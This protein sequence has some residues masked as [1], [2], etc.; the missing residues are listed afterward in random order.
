[1]CQKSLLFLD[2]LR[3]R[4]AFAGLFPIC[5]CLYYEIFL[6]L[7]DLYCFWYNDYDT[8]K[9]H[10]IFEWLFKL[11]KADK[12]A[13][14]LKIKEEI[15]ML[16]VE[17]PKCSTCQRAKKWLNERGISY[18]DRDIKVQNPSADELKEWH[19]KSGLPLKKFFNTSG[20]LYKEMGLKDKLP[21]MSE[22]EQFQVLASDGMLVKRPI[23]VGDEVVLVG[24][25]E[26]EWEI[27]LTGD[28][29]V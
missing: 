7:R 10:L 15:K 21:K 2:W 26:S 9:Y 1:M 4:K 20:V 11:A 27:S 23:L 12:A 6:F 3:D 16:F 28:I 13:I 25:R 17:Y 18:E 29:S 24:F 5:N 19:K 22:E 14:C 8:I